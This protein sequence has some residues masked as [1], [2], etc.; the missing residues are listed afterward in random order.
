MEVRITA[1]QSR[2]KNQTGSSEGGFVAHADV[3][4]TENRRRSSLLVDDKVGRKTFVSGGTYLIQNVGRLVETTE[5]TYVS[6]ARAQPRTRFDPA[7]RAGKVEVE[8]SCLDSRYRSG[9]ARSPL[10]NGRIGPARVY[11]NSSRSPK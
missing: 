2:E 10:S 4:E 9:G 11:W 7:A 1:L 6:R 3:Q 8:R 5:R